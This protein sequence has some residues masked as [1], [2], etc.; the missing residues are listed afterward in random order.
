MKV[1]EVAQDK[2]EDGLPF[3]IIKK[4]PQLNGVVERKNRSIQE[5]GNEEKKNEKQSTSR[6]LE[7]KEE[8]LDGSKVL[9]TP[10][11]TLE[12]LDG[13]WV[14][15]TALRSFGCPLWMRKEYYCLLIYVLSRSQFLSDKK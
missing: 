7:R 14:L 4:I 12:P 8:P 9:W 13:T 15:W 10:L 1:E 6:D 3:E 2:K 5:M 11:W